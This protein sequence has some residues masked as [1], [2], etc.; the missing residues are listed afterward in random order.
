M[1]ITVTVFPLLCFGSGCGISLLLFSFFF[2]FKSL[3]LVQR[4]EKVGS[5]WVGLTDPCKINAILASGSLFSNLHPHKHS[6]R[7]GT[8]PNGMIG[9]WSG[10]IEMQLLQMILFV[11]TS[12]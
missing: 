3:L 8:I 12:S 10:G 9:T 2:F 11:S 7:G 1:F 4:A 5:D 6:R